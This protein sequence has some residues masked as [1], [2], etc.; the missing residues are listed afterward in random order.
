MLAA[1]RQ[2]QRIAQPRRQRPNQLRDNTIAFA[3]EQ[4]GVWSCMISGNII[5]SLV[6]LVGR[7]VTTDTFDPRG[8]RSPPIER[9]APR[10]AQEPCTK[11]RRVFQSID[12]APR[13]QA[14]LLHGFIGISEVA[15]R[16]ERYTS[17]RAMVQF[18]ERAERVGVASLRA[19][20]ETRGLD[21]EGAAVGL[22]GASAREL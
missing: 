22:R 12:P 10:D 15:E 17:C 7:F 2:E 6:L 3:C 13:S 5:K 16:G 11:R 4:G 9:L 8:E 19:R 1:R 20:R 18:D 14:G 21:V